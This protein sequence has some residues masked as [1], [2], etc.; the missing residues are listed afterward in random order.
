MSTTIQVSTAT[1]LHPLLEEGYGSRCAELLKEFR[2][3]Q[4]AVEAF[5]EAYPKLAKVL[6]P[7]L[8]LQTTQGGTPV[9]SLV[10]RLEV[11]PG[12]YEYLSMVARAQ[13]L[14]QLDDALAD[15]ASL[16]LKI[17]SPR[18]TDNANLK[19]WY[20]YLLLHHTTD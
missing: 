6:E 20:A 12:E 19:H 13:M 9:P 16:P 8:V 5:Q 11:A 4:E 14:R 10:H 18:S 17:V 7:L 15:P 2:K 3:G 1:E